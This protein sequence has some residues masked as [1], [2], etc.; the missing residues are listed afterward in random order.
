M[1]NIKMRPL[2]YTPWRIFQWNGFIC[3]HFWF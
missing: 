1:N 3:W 2:R